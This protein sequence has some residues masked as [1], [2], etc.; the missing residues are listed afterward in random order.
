MKSNRQI[1]FMLILTFFT[2]ALTFSAY[3]LVERQPEEGSITFVTTTGELPDKKT[4]FTLLHVANFV[5]SA[6]SGDL[7]TVK[8]YL[9]LGMDPN[10]QDHNKDTALMGAALNGH[11]EIIELLLTH[12]ADPAIK[13]ETGY[14][15][16]DF[17]RIHGEPRFLAQLIKSQSQHRQL[18]SLKKSKQ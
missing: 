5:Y 7:S 18:S 8:K 6:E 14:S 12:N 15:S 9:K 3:H 13:N 2:V 11:E 4:T 10:S 16:F 1:K 17:A